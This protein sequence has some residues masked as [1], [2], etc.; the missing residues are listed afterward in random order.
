M[1]TTDELLEELLAWTK[2][3]YRGQLANELKE[4]L[5]DPKH[6]AAFE[7]SD[8]TRTQAEVAKVA[9]IS[10]ATVS[11]LWAKWRRLALA[12]EVDGRTAHLVRPSDLGLD[13]PRS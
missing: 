8:G 9:G 5:M 4:V 11:A 1:A 13:S 7:A 3:A 12:R 6:L 10:Q 2:F